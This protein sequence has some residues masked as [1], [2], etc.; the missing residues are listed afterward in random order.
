MRIVRGAVLA[1]VVGVLAWVSWPDYWRERIASV[2]SGTDI[3]VDSGTSLEEAIEQQLLLRAERFNLAWVGAELTEAALKEALKSAAAAD[4]YTAYIIDSYYYT[5]RQLS[6]RTDVELRVKYRESAEETASVNGITDDALRSILREG[7]N[8][9]EKVKAIHDWVIDRVSYDDSLQR[10][11]AYEALTTGQAV[12][13]G[14]ALLMHNM[15]TKAGFTAVIAEGEVDSG[16]HAWNMV[17]LDGHWYHLDATW[18]DASAK[19]RS[20]GTGA[21]AGESTN[22]RNGTAGEEN[23]GTAAVDPSKYRYYLLTDEQLRQDHRWTKSYPKAMTVY[24]DVLRDKRHAESGQAKR[25]AALEAALGLDWLAPERTADSATSLAA[26]LREMAAKDKYEWRGR[27]TRGSTWSQDIRE[28]VR[29][30]GIQ[31]GYTVRSTPYGTDGSV[32][33]ELKLL[34]DEEQR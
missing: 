21:A 4:D 26:K 8:D 3:E 11:T 9:H 10:Y 34:T 12:C 6:A 29:E 14:Y 24:A 23:A 17:L 28:A 25:M 22:L 33:L 2:G 13:Q 18:D 31:E 15:L 20:S 5:M 32:L 30:A 16:G 1:L 27:Y 7:M 19:G